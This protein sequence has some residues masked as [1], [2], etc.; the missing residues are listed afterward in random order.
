MI[1][2]LKMKTDLLTQATYPVVMVPQNDGDCRQLELELYA[3]QEPWEIPQDATVRFYYAR[4]DGTGGSYEVLEDGSTS[5]EAEAHRLTLT[6][7]PQIFSKAGNVAAKVEFLQGEKR[8]NTFGFWIRVAHDCTEGAVDA[9]D[10]FNWSV[11]TTQ[12]LEKILRELKESG[13][14][15]GPQ[16]EKGDPG[17]AGTVEN[18]TKAHV[19]AA[20][21]YS[22]AMA[23]IISTTD[24][25]AGSAASDGRPYHVIE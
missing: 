14:F 23:P 12:T 18:M 4:G 16:G 20:L 13:E 8:L 21:G 11:W 19:E 17:E 3:G 1:L 5:W 25:T 7:V 15:D 10:Y 22:P 6:L 24:V 9:Q 2:K